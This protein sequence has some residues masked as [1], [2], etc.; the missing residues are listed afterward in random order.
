MSWRAQELERL[1]GEQDECKKC[2]RLVKCR[3]RV[4]HGRGN[5]EARILIIGEA[6][7]EDEDHDGIAFVGRAGQKLNRLLAQLASPTE[8][9]GEGAVP[10]D[11]YLANGISCRP[12][13]LNQVTE[14][15]E[16]AKPMPDELANCRPW[17]HRII[18][19]VDPSLLILAGE[20]ACGTMGLK[21]AVGKL[22]GNY[23][24]VKVQGVEHE[25]TY[26]ATVIYHPSF[27]LRTRDKP[28]FE[29]NTLQHLHS[30]VERVWAYVRVG[31]GM[32]PVPY[33]TVGEGGEEP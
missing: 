25:I 26:C 30:A 24:D 19:I 22:Q 13:V 16:N 1:Y 2:Q 5:P 9:L 21:G 3:S 17:L 20:Y 6:P 32:S 27:L 4:V 8:S 18:R 7:G 10:D 11:F 31:Q 15:T 14:R 33:A 12:A 28:D 29:K 23:Y